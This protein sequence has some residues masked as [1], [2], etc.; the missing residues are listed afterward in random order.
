METTYKF[1]VGQRIRRK[2]SHTPICPVGF[3]GTVSYI[4]TCNVKLEEIK[5]YNFDPSYF[6]ADNSMM[7]TASSTHLEI[8]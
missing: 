8:Y 4:D 6:E 2:I 7:E 5:G 3:V 1:Y